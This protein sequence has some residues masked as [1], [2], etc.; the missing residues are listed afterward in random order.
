MFNPY[1][2][3]DIPIKSGKIRNGVYWYKY[4][5]GNIV[6]EGM[7]YMDYTIKEAVNKWRKLHPAY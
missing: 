6:I 3:N 1:Y 2:L 5:N 4:Y 7:T